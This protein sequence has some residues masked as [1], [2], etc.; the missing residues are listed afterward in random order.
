MNIQKLVETLSQKSDR[1]ADY[2]PD[3]IIETQPRHDGQVPTI[4]WSDGDKYHGLF[5]YAPTPEGTLK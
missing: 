5:I 3:C 4:G 2:P 1:G